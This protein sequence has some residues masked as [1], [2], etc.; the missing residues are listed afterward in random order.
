MSF[1]RIST[2]FAAAILVVVMMVF[3][4]QGPEIAGYSEIVTLL[5]VL[6][7]TGLLS[8]LTYEPKVLW[9]N[10]RRLYSRDKNR[11]TPS[12]KRMM[13][14]CALYALISGV[15]LAIV[16]V[17]PVVNQVDKSE[18]VQLALWS[19][20]YGVLAAVGFWIISGVDKPGKA[21]AGQKSNLGENQQIILAFCV[22]LLTVGVLSLLFVEISHVNKRLLPDE[23]AG[24]ASGIH[25]GL[26]LGEDLVWRPTTFDKSEKTPHH[27]TGVVGIDNR[28]VQAK[29]TSSETVPQAIPTDAPLRWEL[30]LDTHGGSSK[31]LSGPYS[32]P[33]LQ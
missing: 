14:Q 24:L 12:D 25:T 16:Q 28:L 5:L 6:G 21:D 17:L 30:D 23:S 22:L 26:Q 27:N 11:Q 4:Y 8:V 18:K 20:L 9:N 33:A 29:N 32:Q 19:L 15:L 3:V 31:N 13:S 7:L 1:L 10:L 2:I